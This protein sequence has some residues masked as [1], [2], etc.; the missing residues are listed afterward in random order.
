MQEAISEKDLSFEIKI[1]A[2]KINDEHRGDP[3]PIVFVCVLNGGFMFFSDLVKEITVPIEID[4]IR[5]KSYFGRKQGD[6]VI[7]K[8]LETKIKGKHVYIVDD[9]LDS[10]NTMG[11]VIKFLQVKEP[12]SLTPIV[13][14]YKE[15]NLNFPK[16][17]HIIKQDTDSVF[18]PW[19]IGYGMDD[20]NGYNRNLKTIYIV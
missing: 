10:G 11:A 9:I 19:Y 20:D 17:H 3:T 5:Y 12:K 16:V 14:L 18:D 15:D 6:L 1:L 4:F 8:D 2:K 7:T 13:A